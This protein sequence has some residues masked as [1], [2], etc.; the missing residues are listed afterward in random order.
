MLIGWSG[1]V[2]QGA[3][4]LDSIDKCLSDW[5]LEFKGSSSD[6][7]TNC[8]DFGVELNSKGE[9]VLNFCS[10]G[11]WVGCLIKQIGSWIELSWV[12]EN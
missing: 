7:K 11:W 5:M 12:G 4:Y 2:E 6:M 9:I 10:N 3:F 8:K 1:K